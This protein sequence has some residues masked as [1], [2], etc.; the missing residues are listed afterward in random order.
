MFMRPVVDDLLKVAIRRWVNCGHEGMYMVSNNAQIGRGIQAMINS[1]PKVCQENIPNS[2]APP[3]AWTV[4]TRQIWAAD[5]KPSVHHLRASAE[6][7]IHQTKLQ[8]SSFQVSSFGEACAH[9]VL[10]FLFL[11]DR[12]GT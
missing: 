8:V 7:K 9:C 2:I 3:P 10:S 12:S 4:D 6:I 11:V 1:G 5:A